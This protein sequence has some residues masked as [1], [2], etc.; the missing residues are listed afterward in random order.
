MAMSERQIQKEILRLKKDIDLLEGQIQSGMKSKA[1]KEQENARLDDDILKQEAENKVLEAEL[2]KQESSISELDEE[3]KENQL[4]AGRIRKEMNLVNEDLEKKTK[5]E[6]NLR[7]N[8]ELLLN[9]IE[10]HK[11]K[12]K[13]EKRSRENAEYNLRKTNAKVAE[14]QSHWASK[15]VT[16]KI[17]RDTK[18]EG[19]KAEEIKRDQTDIEAYE[20]AIEESQRAKVG[21]TDREVTTDET[22]GLVEDINENVVDEVVEEKKEDKG[23]DL[24]F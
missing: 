14:I 22:V 9:N 21:K 12:I 15:T 18:R 2:E 20:A 7:V 23:L 17:A 13:E 10:T 19:R 24:D 8:V 6:K 1:D 5:E 4:K 3:F 11:K 16:S